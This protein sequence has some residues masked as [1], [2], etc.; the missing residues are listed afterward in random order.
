MGI[1][2]DPNPEICLR[3]PIAYKKIFEFFRFA[4]NN[5]QEPEFDRGLS[6]EKQSGLFHT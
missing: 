6:T 4:E 1:F 2:K 3:L 5:F